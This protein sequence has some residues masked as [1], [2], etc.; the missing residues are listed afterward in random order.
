MPTLTPAA[1]LARAVSR[2]FPNEPEGYRAAREA[3]IA[4][5]IALR[6]HLASV[7]EQRRALP[8]GGEVPEDYEFEGPDGGRVR[9]SEMFG[10]HDT[11]V[12]YFWMYGPQRERPCPMCTNLLGPLDANARDIEQQVA[13]AVI[14]LSPVARQLEFARER[15]WTALRLYSS[16]GNDFARD[17]RG[18][19]D[20]GTDSAAL[21]VFVKRD[22][23]VHL[24]WAAEAGFGTED[25]GKDPSLA[26][27]LAPLWNILD[28]TPRGRD[29][30]W[31]PS[32]DY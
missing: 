24:F 29:P 32:L 26:P 7:A 4:E 21:N 8:I 22:G 14:A 23:K 2:P 13:L 25:P 1:E 18:L 20:D 17:Y 27:D 28:L 31:Y 9:L 5:E 10:P 3:L 30:H 15:G 19:M 16:A 12:T 6:R 11:L